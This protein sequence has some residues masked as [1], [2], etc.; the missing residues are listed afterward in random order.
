MNLCLLI[1]ALVMDEGHYLSEAGDLSIYYLACF[2]NCYA[3]V[4][5][6]KNRETRTYYTYKTTFFKHLHFLRRQ[7]SIMFLVFNE[8]FYGIAFVFRNNS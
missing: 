7:F 1:Q 8:F 6:F 5:L 4:S 3:P 2:P